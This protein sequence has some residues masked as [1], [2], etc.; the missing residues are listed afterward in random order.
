MPQ[1][2]WRSQAWKPSKKTWLGNCENTEN[3][4]EFISLF[5]TCAQINSLPNLCTDKLPPFH[6]ILICISWMTNAF[7]ISHFTSWHVSVKSIKSEWVCYKKLESSKKVPLLLL[8][9]QRITY[10][11]STNLGRN[12]YFLPSLIHFDKSF[13]C[14]SATTVMIW[15]NSVW[16]IL[17]QTKH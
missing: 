5:Q 16:Q 7:D 12:L 2:L 11:K 1:V 6:K 17:V 9:C 3:W 10:T 14:L 13:F 8:H 15:V 4:I